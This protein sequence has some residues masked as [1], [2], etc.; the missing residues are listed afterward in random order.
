MH[1]GIHVCRQCVRAC[2]ILCQP[3]L[4]FLQLT[5]SLR[6]GGARWLIGRV[7][8]CRPEA[9]GF[10]SRYNRHLGPL[11]NSITHSCLWHIGVKLGH[12]IL[13]VPGVSLSSSGLEEAL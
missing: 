13:A 4:V 10:E 2:D 6:K 1:G 9:R 12:S 5:P 7:D 11:G 8:S 3:F